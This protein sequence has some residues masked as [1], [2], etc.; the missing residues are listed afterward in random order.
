MLMA[1]ISLKSARIVHGS[2]TP[3]NIMLSNHNEYTFS[4]RLIYFKY[5][6]ETS[7]VSECVF[8]ETCRF[9]APDVLD[10]SLLDMGTWLYSGILRFGKHY[11]STNCKYSY[12]KSILNQSE[13]IEG[14]YLSKGRRVRRVNLAQGHPNQIWDFKSGNK[15]KSSTGSFERRNVSF[16]CGEAVC[17]DPAE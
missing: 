6:C 3:S 17:N 13:Q 12:L 16:S 7:K 10:C 4:T 9:S 2:I 1:L 5:V 8:P 11:F 14:S 15:Y